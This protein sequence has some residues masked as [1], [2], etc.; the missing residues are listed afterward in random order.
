MKKFVTNQKNIETKT[1]SFSLTKRHSGKLL[2]INI[3]TSNTVTVPPAGDVNWDIGDNIDL[4][5]YGLGQTTIVGGIGVTVLSNNG[6]LDMGSAGEELITGRLTY[7]G[8]DIWLFENNLNYTDPLSLLNIY[9]SDG[10]LDGDRV[11]GMGSNILT[12]EG[13]DSNL[14]YLPNSFGGYLLLSGKNSDVPRIAVTIPSYSTKPTAGFSL[15][16]RAWDDVSFSGYGKVGD[17]FFYGGNETN[18]INF[19]NPQGTDTEDYIRF[20][21]G[22]I[23]NDSPDIHIQGTGATIGNVGIGTITPSARLQVKGAGTTSATKALSV[24]NSAGTELVISK[25]NGDFELNVGTGF[26]NI[27]F[28]SNGGVNRSGIFGHNMRVGVNGTNCLSF[29][30]GE[31]LIGS[32]THSGTNNFKSGSGITDSYI[33]FQLS[34]QTTTWFH[35]RN[36]KN[37]YMTDSASNFILGV[38]NTFWMQSGTAPT[39]GMVDHSVF[40]VADQTAGNACLH[41]RTENGSIIKLYRESAVTTPQGIADA[42]TNIGLLA[43]S[44]ISASSTNIYNSDG[45][46]TGTRVVTLGGNSLTFTGGQTTLKGSGTTSATKT[47]SIQNSAGTEKL[48][49]RDDGKF[50]VDSTGVDSRID[51][52]GNKLIIGYAG[53]T[54]AQCMGINYSGITHPN[55][56]LRLFS[57]NGTVILSGGNAGGSFFNSLDIWANGNIAFRVDNN[58]RVA[59]TTDS[60]WYNGNGGFTYQANDKLIIDGKNSA[61]KN[62]SSVP[63]TNIAD[64]CRLYASDQVAG[65]SCLHTRTE[66]GAI[67]KIYQETTAV[68]SSVFVA[69]I[70]NN[71]KEDSTFDGYTVA[72][73]VKA[74]RNLGILA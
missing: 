53:L 54:D 12:F 49:V 29:A 41:T 8:T 68:T 64:H 55:D 35:A 6:V 60:S 20:Y 21:A 27:V 50:Y 2:K 59:I 19:I 36:G 70:G 11:V 7:L 43:S 61:W 31:G 30:V 18:G 22:K 66:N 44:T 63:S 26:G 52:T 9:N 72:Q 71:V 38:S 51:V 46:L 37:M 45:T 23:A 16:M 39:S 58:Q 10:T 3:A 4:L 25:N 42:L 57:T 13:T 62:S 17:G 74:L 28:T 67:V 1:S 32:Y 65:N 15:G 34:N 24:Q 48:S 40:Y 56:H 14:Q 5:Q 69:N 33:S 47:L 73:V